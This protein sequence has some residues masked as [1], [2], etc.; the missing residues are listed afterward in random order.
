MH[1][2]LPLP[3]ICTITSLLPRSTITSLLPRYAPSPPFSPDMQ[4]GYVRGRSSS[5]LHIPSDGGP[6]PPTEKATCPAC[7]AQGVCVC[8]CVCFNVC[9]CCVC[10]CLCV[11]CVFVC[12]CVC[13]CVCVCVGVC[14]SLV[15]LELFALSPPPPPPSYPFSPPL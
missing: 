9:M 5:S 8:V 14:I 3:Q 1:H 2:H 7:P 11:F 4:I 12:L 10:V 6:L 15:S 13:V